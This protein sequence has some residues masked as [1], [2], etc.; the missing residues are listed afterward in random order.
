MKVKAWKEMTKAEKKA[1]IKGQ[2]AENKEYADLV[3]EIE[4]EEEE[5]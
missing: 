4:E 5:G 3:A 2:R 1:F